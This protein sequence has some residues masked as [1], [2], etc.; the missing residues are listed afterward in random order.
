MTERHILAINL[1][2]YLPIFFEWRLTAGI[3]GYISRSYSPLLPAF[4]GLW[5]LVG[6]I[7]LF[8]VKAKPV[9]FVI[10]GFPIIAHWGMGLAWWLS[11]LGHV[12]LG[13]F[14]LPLAIFININWLVHT[15]IRAIAKGESL[16]DTILPPGAD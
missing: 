8:R 3:I 4:L 14:F 16:D 5:A 6:L 2:C 1:A 9:A 7:Y 15:R 11:D 12:P 10:C 13:A